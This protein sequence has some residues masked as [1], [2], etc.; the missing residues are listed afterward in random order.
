MNK[1]WKLSLLG[2][3]LWGQ[4]VVARKVRFPT[5]IC[6]FQFRRTPKCPR[7]HPSVS[8]AFQLLARLI[9]NPLNRDIASRPARWGNKPPVIMTRSTISPT[10]L[11]IWVAKFSKMHCIP[12]RIPVFN[13]DP[14]SRGYLGARY[15]FPCWIISSDEKIGVKDWGSPRLNVPLF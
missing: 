1:G 12:F 4:D 10:I 6:Y 15:V 13:Y 3:V 8:G 7:W 9:F 5:Q 11:P 14:S 2:L